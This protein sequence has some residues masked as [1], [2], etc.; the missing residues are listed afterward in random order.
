MASLSVRDVESSLERKGFRRRDGH[1]TFF[2]YYST[3]NV[4]TSIR[5]KVSHGAKEI[6][7]KLIGAMARQCRLS[8]DDFKG[9]V[10]CTLGREQYEV[11]LIEA[12]QVRVARSASLSVRSTATRRRGN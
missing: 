5:T 1:H 6:G 8:K 7:D 10:E 11:M 12:G 4:K 9:L 2:V 3:E